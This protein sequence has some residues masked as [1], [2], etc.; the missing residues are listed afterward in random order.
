MTSAL[1]DPDLAPQGSHKID[2][3]ATWSPVLNRVRERFRDEEVV[4]GRRMGVILPLEPKTAYLAQVLA[5]AGAEVALACPAAFTKDDVA[6]ALADRGVEVFA[7]SD[8]SPEQ[9]RHFYAQVLARRPEVVI[10]DRAELIRMAHTSHRHALEELRG[11]TELTTSGVTAL[12][13]MER[14][15]VLAVPCIAANDAN[16]KHY[17]D[18]RYGSG[19]SVL[20][21]IQDATN[22]LLAGKEVLVV[23]YGWVGRGIASR[24]RGKGARVTIA[25]VDPFAALEAYNDGFEVA[26]VAQACRRANL[27]ITATGCR[28]ALGQ[29]QIE[30]LGDGTLLANA[31]GV[32]DEFDMDKLRAR[33]LEERRVRPHVAEFL[34]DEDH[35]IFVIGDGKVV[36]LSAGEG[37]PVEIM[38][39]SFSVQALGARHLL[40][41][42]EE[43]EPGVHLLPGEIDD[44]IARDKLASLGLEIDRLSGE[45]QRFL[46]GWE[47]PQ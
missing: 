8:A 47:A 11:A 5:E 4:K 14:E 19:Q 7:R 45:Q 13:A 30:L 25:E 42:A 22:L 31:G 10:D 28:E 20:Q 34:L 16:C 15:G 26:A 35:S 2:W 1:L 24:A 27:V 12:R 39:L 32:D 9:E 23:G 29:E 46:S 44:Q 40:L 36:N 37:H 6:A 43:M 18:N 3:A 17:Y 38:D 21:A 33:A 41:H